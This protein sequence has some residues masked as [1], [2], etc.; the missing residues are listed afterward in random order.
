[1]GIDYS[2]HLG[3]GYILDREDIIA[4]FRVEIPEKFHMEDRFDPKTGVKLEPVKVV[5]EGGQE[6]FEYKGTRYEMEYEL[7]EAIGQD[8]GCCIDNC[9]GYSDG[10]TIRV[11][12]DL[13]TDDSGIDDGR[14]TVGGAITFDDL[15]SRRAELITLKKAFKKLGIDLG[16]AKVFPAWNIS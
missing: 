15:T 10:E 12:L 11:T 4:P 7:F 8:L 14:F 6:E 13:D 5:D 1:M 16:E 3:V 9:G 2:V